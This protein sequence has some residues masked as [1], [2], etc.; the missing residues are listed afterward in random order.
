VLFRSFLLNLESTT[1][2]ERKF[3][4]QFDIIFVSPNGYLHPCDD[5]MMNFCHTKLKQGGL[6]ASIMLGPDMFM[7]LSTSMNFVETDQEEDTAF[8][9]SFPTRSQWQDKMQQHGMSIW[10][11]KEE[12]YRKTYSSSRE[13]FQIA[14]MLGFFQ[15]V[16]IEKNR[17][18]QLFFQ[19]WMKF[20][21]RGFRTKE[22][23][24]YTTYH[25]IEL[26]GYFL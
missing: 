17:E 10:E 11:S 2:H 20:Y 25:L 1:L 6:F 19:E 26:I 13:L 21:D 18:L 4:D 22:G 15:T 8:S 5:E 24:I 12:W 16:E 3:P 14:T 23:R 7:E 9:I